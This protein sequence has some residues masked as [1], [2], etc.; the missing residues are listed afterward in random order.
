MHHVVGD[1]VFDT[2]PATSTSSNACLYAF[3]VYVNDF[4]SILIPT[5][6]NQLEH[7]T[8]AFMTGIHNVFLAEVGDGNNPYWR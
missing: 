6:R 2:L 7:V 4:M 3:E 8:R 1:M 5:S